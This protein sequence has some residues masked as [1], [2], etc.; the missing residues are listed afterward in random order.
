MKKKHRFLPLVLALCMGISGMTPISVEAKGKDKGTVIDVTDYGAEADN[1]KD[2][3]EA[4]IKA[5]AA[6][7]KA[8]DAGENV[9]IS[10]PKGRYDIYPDKIKAIPTR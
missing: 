5:V 3:A 4:I 9:T 10:F 2:N 8:S 7:K 6:A 1:G